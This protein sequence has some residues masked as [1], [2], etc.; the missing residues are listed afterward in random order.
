MSATIIPTMIVEDVELYVQPG[1][2]SHV[3]PIDCDHLW[4]PHYCEV[5]RACC[6]RCQA[7]AR[8]I[9]TRE[10]RE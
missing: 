4:E 9:D 10:Q 6:G 7:L 5:R 2:T 3:D 8:W 1:L